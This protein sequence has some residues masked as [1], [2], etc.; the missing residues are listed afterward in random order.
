[1]KERHSYR[2]GLTLEEA[3]ACVTDITEPVRDV[4]WVKLSDCLGRIL[5]QDMEAQFDN[6]PFDRSPVDGYACRAADTKGADRNHPVL[7]KVVEEI[8][9][10]QYSE[11][12]IRPGEAVRIMT[13]AAIPAGCDCCLRQESTN[14]GESTVEIYEEVSVHD[15]YCDRGEDF[16][17][18]TQMM[19]AG[20]KLGYIETGNLAGMGC[21]KV[22]VYRR[23]RIALITTGDEVTLPGT[24]LLPGR[25]YNSNR[26][27]LEARLKELGCE[28]MWVESTGDDA[29]KVAEQ[30]KRA[31]DRGADLILTTGGVSVG[32]K[33]ILHEALPLLGAVKLFWRVR[34]KPGTPTICSLYH[35]IPVISLSGNPFG[36]ITNL[37]LLV[38]PMLAR[39]TNDP[40]LQVQV[41]SGIM[42]SSFPKESRGRRFIRAIYGG[43]KVCL[44]DGLHSSGVLSS[45]KGCNCLVDIAPGTKA[46]APGDQ[47][48]VWLL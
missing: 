25:I 5:A 45:M 11:R 15:N 38:R 1:M 29:M 43:G 35:G 9:A 42:E 27:L 14:Y 22:P 26:F 7:L 33:D 12:E 2:E 21:E 47:V 16:K 30:V 23:P 20:E 10:G 4:E 41:V 3:V 24:P 17:A 44:P 31:A 18:G 48:R 37:E 13:G 46:L 40:S 39:L 19:K 28:A 6:P 32:K 34:L 8:D 36:A